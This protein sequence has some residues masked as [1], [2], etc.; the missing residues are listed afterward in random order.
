MAQNC[1]RCNMGTNCKGASNMEKM[2]SCK[3]YKKPQD[4]FKLAEIVLAHPTSLNEALSA[5]PF[6]ANI[7]IHL[8]GRK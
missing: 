2:M 3:R 8:E 6:E 7:G 5:L 1:N 4:T